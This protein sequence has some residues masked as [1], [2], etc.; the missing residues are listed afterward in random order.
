MANRRYYQTS[1]N[2]HGQSFQIPWAA[3]KDSKLG[4]WQLKEKS[5]VSVSDDNSLVD[6][7]AVTNGINLRQ[8]LR[9]HLPPIRNL[10][11][12]HFGDGRDA[13]KL[14]LRELS[15]KLIGIFIQSFGC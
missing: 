13:I 7:M 3:R 9:N 11:D 10:F 12:A 4:I 1:D 6:T 5:R 2:S 8:C 14:F 15:K